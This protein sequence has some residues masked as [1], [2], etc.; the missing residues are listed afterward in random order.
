MGMKYGRFLAC[1]RQLLKCLHA[2]PPLL[3]PL[4]P[5]PPT[6]PFPSLRLP[7]L[8]SSEYT[9][10]PRVSHTPAHICYLQF[11]QCNIILFIYLPRSNTQVRLLPLTLYTCLVVIHS[12]DYSPIFFTPHSH[13]LTTLP[14]LYPIL[15]IPFPSLPVPFT[16]PILYPLLLPY[17]SHILHFSSL[18]L[19]ISCNPQHP[20]PSLTH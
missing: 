17:T 10:T 12:S 13:A 2:T 1:S 18:A 16:L 8:P 7:Y 4:I 3:F 9:H 14:I 11:R 5:P 15:P 20:S 6:S 19:R